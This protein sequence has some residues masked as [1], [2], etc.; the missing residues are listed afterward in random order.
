M[1][2][3]RLKMKN[4][5]DDKEEKIPNFRKVW[6]HKNVFNYVKSFSGIHGDKPSF[7]GGVKKLIKLADM[8]IFKTKSKYKIFDDD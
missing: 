6:V 3:R 1:K 2:M 5:K 7:N 8:N 4:D